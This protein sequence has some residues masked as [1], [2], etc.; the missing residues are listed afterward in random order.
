MTTLVTGAT[1]HIGNNLV[2]ALLA[3]KERVRVLVRAGSNPKPL[4]G[5]EVERGRTLSL[6]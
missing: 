5:L 4:A 3:R 6:L 2:R 1:G